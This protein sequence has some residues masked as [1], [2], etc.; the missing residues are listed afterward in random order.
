MCALTSQPEFQVR[1]GYECEDGCVLGCCPVENEG[2]FVRAYC[3]I[4]LKLIALM[5]ESIS[6]SENTSNSLPDYTA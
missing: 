2:C 1:L 3:S 6:P 5:M 4:I